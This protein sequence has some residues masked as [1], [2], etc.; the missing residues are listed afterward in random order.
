MSMALGART[1]GPIFFFGPP[2][3]LCA[4][5]YVTEISLI[6]TLNNQFTSPRLGDRKISN[7]KPQ[8]G[9]G[10]GLHW[11]IKSYML[12]ITSTRMTYKSQTTS[13]INFEGLQMKLIRQKICQI[14][15]LL[16]WQANVAFFLIQ[17]IY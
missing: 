3:H 17:E 9:G 10:G 6:V 11:K 14:W 12:I 8:N 15:C 1:V 16:L 5:T 2:A 4:V 7:I 13:S